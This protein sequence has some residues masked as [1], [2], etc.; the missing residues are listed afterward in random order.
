MM[1]QLAAHTLVVVC[2]RRSY[3]LA[4]QICHTV[5]ESLSG[6]ERD[7]LGDF[8]R[9]AVAAPIPED[10]QPPHE[11]SLCGAGHVMQYTVA[12]FLANINHAARWP[13]T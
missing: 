4:N 6:S 5:I 2:P 11:P 9:R 8:R 1:S 3:T 7:L 13:A 12:K 10:T